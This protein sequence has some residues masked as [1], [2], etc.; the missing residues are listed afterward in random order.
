MTQTTKWPETVMF[1]GAGATCELGF[2]TTA[3]QGKLFIKLSEI[4]Q[5][6]D[7]PEK[8]E[9]FDFF[10]GTYLEEM[11][12]LLYILDDDINADSFSERMV[13]NISDSQRDKARELFKLSSEDDVTNLVVNLRYTYDFS[14]LKQL[15]RLCTK[16]KRTIVMTVFN[17]ID[18]HVGNNEGLVI[19]E[20]RGDLLLESRRLLGARNALIMLVVSSMTGAYLN[21]LESKR[22][23]IR[24]YKSFAAGLASYMQEEGEDRR[25]LPQNERDF[26]LFSYA[27]ISLNWD[28][29]LNWMIFNAHK[30]FNDDPRN[31]CF[32]GRHIRLKFF[33]DF[34]IMMGL[35]ELRRGPGDELT[36]K[37]WY[38]YNET[39][40]QRINDP[41]YDHGKIVRMGKYYYPHGCLAWRCCPNCGS[42]N[43]SFGD[44]WDEGSE[45]LFPPSLVPA[46]RK[47][48]DRTELEERSVKEGRHDVISCLYC[49]AETELKDTMLVMQSAVKSNA[50][51]ALR[52]IQSDINASLQHAK[53][54]I[55]MGYSLPPDD[56]V[57]RSI[58]LARKGDVK[59]S[60]VVGIGGPGHWQYCSKPENIEGGVDE[61]FETFF[62]IFQ[63]EGKDPQ[64]NMRFYTKGIPEVFEDIEI[65]ELLKW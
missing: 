33:N 64:E 18:Y 55:F 15:L 50:P 19:K 40:V 34:A 56:M 7:Y 11:A 24:K 43:G 8:L 9:E 36:E 45:S 49:D 62:D 17:L 29:F 5:E 4:S 47:I 48:V 39:V 25:D 46:F 57:W 52:I 44:D 31:D 32:A 27:V 12:D 3:R 42:M 1:W 41:D 60:V 63:A 58:L 28:H 38:P 6:E 35:R 30:D 26:Y 21:A 22:D 13:T 59:V 2:P 61:R 37:I 51:P 23:V 54:I 14:A 20:E 65:D 16:N 53:H 10:T